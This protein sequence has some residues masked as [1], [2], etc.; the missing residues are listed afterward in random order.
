MGEDGAIIDETMQP[1]TSIYSLSNHTNIEVYSF[2]DKYI[3][4]YDDHRSILN[5]IFEAKRLGLFGAAPNIIF[6]DR[7]DDACNPNLNVGELLG[8]WGV[9]KIEEVTSQYFWSFVEFDLSGVDDDWLLAGMELGLINHAVVI[10]QNENHN[11]RDMN[12]MFESSDG[13]HHELFDISHLDWSIGSRGCLGD[14]VI[15][16][17]YY[18]NVRNIFEYNQPPYGDYDKF[19]KEVTN[20]FVLDFDLDC[21]TTECEDNVYAWPEAIFREK[22][23]EN[24]NVYHFMRRLIE[25]STFITICREPTCCGGLGESNKI[26]GYLDRYFF[27]GCLDTTPIR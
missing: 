12:N 1:I 19:S 3:I 5:V 17:E 11:I 8:K 23:F 9:D 13:I 25:R 21:F 18:E 26:L 7:H 24:K 2:H 27:E 20:P 4:L 16:E 15:K 10:G 6:F 14:N 22:Y